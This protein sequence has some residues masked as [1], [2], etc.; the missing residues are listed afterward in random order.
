M[1]VNFSKRSN[2]GIVLGILVAAVVLVVAGTG[3]LRNN[4][5]YFVGELAYSFL[6]L[7]LALVAYDKLLVR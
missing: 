2:I 5:F 4:G 6:I 7:I 1:S 3:W